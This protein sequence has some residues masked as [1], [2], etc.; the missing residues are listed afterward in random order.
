[1]SVQPSRLEGAVSGNEAPHGCSDKS[2]EFHQV[3]LQ[4]GGSRLVGHDLHTGALNARVVRHGI[5]PFRADIFC[6]AGNMSMDVEARPPDTPF[7]RLTALIPK[8]PRG[9]GEAS[10]PP[11]LM[12]RYSISFPGRSNL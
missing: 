4:E 12:E 1:M 3:R 10:R 8:D 5:L 6:L 9:A 2:G 11:L 7:Y